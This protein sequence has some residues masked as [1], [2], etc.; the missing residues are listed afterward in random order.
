MVKFRL[1]EKDE[2]EEIFKLYNKCK[3]DLIKK[4]ILQWG[5]WDHNFDGIFSNSS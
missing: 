5:E 2:F 1:A 4:N 3:R